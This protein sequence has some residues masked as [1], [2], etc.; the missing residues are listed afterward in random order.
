MN[1]WIGRGEHNTLGGHF[2]WFLNHQN[3]G[4]LQPEPERSMVDCIQNHGIKKIHAALASRILWFG[5]CCLQ[6]TKPDPK[7]CLAQDPIDRNLAAMSSLQ[8]SLPSFTLEC[9]KRTS[10]GQCGHDLCTKPSTSNHRWG[11]TI[12][13]QPWIPP[14]CAHVLPYF[15][16]ICSAFRLLKAS[17]ASR[18]VSFLWNWNWQI[19][20]HERETTHISQRW[21]NEV[22][23]QVSVSYEPACKSIW[24]FCVFTSSSH[25]KNHL[26]QHPNI[27]LRPTRGQATCCSFVSSWCQASTSSSKVAPRKWLDL[28]R[29]TPSRRHK[30]W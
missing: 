20:N 6:P 9:I 8:D 12:P 17:N 15:W 30:G 24:F 14:A 3:S 23:Q 19:Q 2:S 27:Y 21:E 28:M 4:R 11:S 29:K 1:P 25:L 22:K 5:A 18:F 13:V 16:P 26:F 7:S 10:C